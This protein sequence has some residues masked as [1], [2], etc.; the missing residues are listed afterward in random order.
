MVER[1]QAGNFKK[2]SDALWEIGEHQLRNNNITFVLKEKSG[3]GIGFYRVITRFCFLSIFPSRLHTSLTRRTSG[4]SPETC[5][6]TSTLPD[7]GC[8]WTET[9]FHIFFKDLM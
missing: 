9:C 3:T 5:E 6:H 1:T 8:R 7:L 4:R 2:K